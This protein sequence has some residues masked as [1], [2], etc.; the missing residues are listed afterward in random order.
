MYIVQIWNSSV[1]VYTWQPKSHVL[2]RR[3]HHHVLG[4]ELD[5]PHWTCVVSIEYADF[6]AIFSIPDMDSAVGGPRDN[7][8]TVGAKGSFQWNRFCIEMTSKRL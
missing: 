4:V 3:R 1:L 6:C 5:A 8:L 7:K 2:A